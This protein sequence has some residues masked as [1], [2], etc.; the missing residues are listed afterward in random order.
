MRCLQPDPRQRPG[1]GAGGGRRASRRRSAGRGAGRRRDAFAR[2]W[3][4]P[5]ERRKGSSPKF[6]L[7]WLAAA[8]VLIA[9]GMILGPRVCITSKL[10]LENS[11]DALTRDARDAHP[12]LRL[13]RQTRR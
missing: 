2:I 4:P 12:Q 13:H 5:P 11:P 1:F 10:N 8:L 9:A 6:A 7:A 3:W